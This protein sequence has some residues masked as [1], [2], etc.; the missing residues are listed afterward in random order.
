[1][2]YLERFARKRRNRTETLTARVDPDTY[3]R[4]KEHCDRLGL[5]VS[6]GVALLVEK[7][8]GSDPVTNVHTYVPTE[9]AGNTNVH[10][11]VR[12]EH[13]SIRRYTPPPQGKYGGKRKLSPDGRKEWCSLCQDWRSAAHF[14]RHCRDVHNMTPDQV[15]EKDSET[16]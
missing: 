15:R 5:T 10:T 13:E 4:F 16:T 11:S 12:T 2:G 7:E 1:M 6:E 14:G 8:V 9:P 3:K